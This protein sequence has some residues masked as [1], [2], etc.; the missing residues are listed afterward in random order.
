MKWLWQTLIYDFIRVRHHLLFPFFA[1]I[2]T[3]SFIVCM[4]LTGVKETQYYVFVIDVVLPVFASWISLAFMQPLLDEVGGDLYFTFPIS[5]MYLGLFRIVVGYLSYC[6]LLTTAFIVISIIMDYPI[7]FPF[8][9][10][11]YAQALFYSGLGF[12]VIAYS[13][14]MVVGII[15]TFS[16]PLFCLASNSPLIKSFTIYGNFYSWPSL[17]DHISEYS[18][19]SLL[20]GI[21]GFG[22]AQSQISGINNRS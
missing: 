10:L 21:T 13:H 14:S 19:R 6:V 5:R 16:I 15:V 18:L 20:Y 8:L 2:L 11:L 9:L 12:V 3:V 17:M 1:P 7:S 22:L 4:K